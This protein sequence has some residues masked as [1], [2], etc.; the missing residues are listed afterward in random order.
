VKVDGKW[1]FS[2]RKIYNEQVKDWIY[3]GGNPAW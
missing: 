2:K 1:Y 3:T